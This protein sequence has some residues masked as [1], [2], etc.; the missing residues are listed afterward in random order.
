DSYRT[1]SAGDGAPTVVD[2]IGQCLGE[3]VLPF[4]P[5]DLDAL[6]DGVVV[7]ARGLGS[8][9]FSAKANLL[10][11]TNPLASVALP[12]PV[13]SLAV[14]QGTAIKVGACWEIGSEYEMRAQKIAAGRVRLGWYRK[15]S[16][17]FIVTA[18][19]SA[20]I[21]AG[22]SSTDLFPTIIGAI[23]ANAQADQN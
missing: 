10:A 8:L 22:T 23:S 19:A 13:P 3:L 17:E 16:S 11:I 12:A 7:T 6:P 15:H 2:A 4:H 1:F 9:K 18:S 14:T 5:D 20:G 21:Q